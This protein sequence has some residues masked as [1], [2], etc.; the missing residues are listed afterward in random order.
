MGRN[1]N[2]GVLDGLTNEGFGDLFHLDQNHGRDFLG[3]KPFY[4]SFELDNNLR[5]VIR[6]RFNLKWPV[7]YFLLDE[8]VVEISP[9]ESFGIENSV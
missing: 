8:V 1:S 9:E 3:I 2:N 4:L 5:L 6:S 7:F